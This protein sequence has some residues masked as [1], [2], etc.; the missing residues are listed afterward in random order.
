MR[1]KSYN[2]PNVVNLCSL[3]GRVYK[4]DGH[5]AYPLGEGR[6]CEDCNTGKVVPERIHRMHLRQGHGD[7]KEVARWKKADRFVQEE[8]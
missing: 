5:N 2:Q 6:C 1:G 3:C 7:P 4:G 8:T